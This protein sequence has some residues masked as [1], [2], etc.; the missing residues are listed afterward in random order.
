MA[1]HCPERSIN[2]RMRLSVPGDCGTLYWSSRSPMY[3]RWAIL[4]AVAGPR[5]A[6]TP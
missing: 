1:D 2:F 3:P 5:M 6:P 4:T